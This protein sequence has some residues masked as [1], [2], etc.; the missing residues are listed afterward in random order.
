MKGY[1]QDMAPIYPGSLLF[2]PL[3]PGLRESFLTRRSLF[4][5]YHHNGDQQYYDQLSRACEQ[6]YGIVRD[7]S[8]VRIFDTDS[9]EYAMRR[10][11][12]NHITGTA[13]TIVLCGA[14]TPWRKYIDWEI[15]ATLDK[16]HGL[17]GVVLPTNPIY[18]GIYRVPDRLFDNIQSGFASWVFWQDLLQGPVYVKALI[19]HAISCSKELI[20]NS[21]E[22][23][24]YNGSR[25]Q[26]LIMP[27]LL[28]R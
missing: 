12:E 8:P 15:K 6:H 5:S 26:S 13:C 25:L 19:E 16:E 21:R 14:E 2:Q 28:N 3:A 20:K 7:N 27:S 11:R 1:I 22:M 17:I 10:I 18:G 24:C 9:A 23:R 4:I